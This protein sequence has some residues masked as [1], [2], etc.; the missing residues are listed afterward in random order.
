MRP[1]KERVF[2]VEAAGRAKTL[3]QIGGHN[4]GVSVR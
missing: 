1:S 3:V 4:W 2:Q